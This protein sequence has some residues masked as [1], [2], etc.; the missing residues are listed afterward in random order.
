MQ[1][2][3]VEPIECSWW[4]LTIKSGRAPGHLFLPKQFQK[5][6]NWLL[7]IDLFWPISVEEQLGD[8]GVFAHNVLFLIDRHSCVTRSTG[9]LSRGKFQNKINVNDAGKVTSFGTAR[10]NKRSPMNFNG[11]SVEGIVN[12]YC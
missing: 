4:R 8:S 9:K 10:R 12:F 3:L 6:L 7:L 1:G 2:Q 11:G 5:R